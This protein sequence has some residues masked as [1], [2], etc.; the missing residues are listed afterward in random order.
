[1]ISVNTANTG[2]LCQGDIIK[3]VLHI[4][5][6]TIEKNIL[7]VEQIRFPLIVVLTQDCDLN[8]DFDHRTK[9]LGKNQ[10]KHILSVL[11]A[12]VY[13]YEHVLTGSHL[14]NLDRQMQQIKRGTTQ[15]QNLRNNEI[16]RYHFL[17]FPAEIPVV[18]S[19]I[20]FKHYFSVDVESL[21]SHRKTSLVCEISPLFRESISVRFSYYL[22]RIG[23]PIIDSKASAKS[24]S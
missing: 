19:V 13:N 10:D 17:D 12:P 1:M 2:R 24:G 8:Q 4:Q 7:T 6:A 5:K 14:S 15:D 20:D 23:L 21:E 18:K 22:S 9:E 3:D 16:P 11:V